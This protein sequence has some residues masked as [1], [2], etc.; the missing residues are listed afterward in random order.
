MTFGDLMF[1]FFSPAAERGK[2]GDGILVS[3]C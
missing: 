1:K 3:L 2:Y